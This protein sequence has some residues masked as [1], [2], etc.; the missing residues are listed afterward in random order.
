MLTEGGLAYAQAEP[1]L[2]G[3]SMAPCTW[4]GIGELKALYTCAVT[5]PGGYLGRLVWNTTASGT[6]QA[7]AVFVQYRDL[8]GNKIR[9]PANHQVPIGIGPILLENEN[10][11]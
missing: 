1:W 5:R 7:P 2:L 3:A 9:I 8:Q 4:A 10:P 6:Y 11:P